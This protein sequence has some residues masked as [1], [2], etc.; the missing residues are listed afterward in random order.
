MGRPKARERELLL[1]IMF[2]QHYL[3]RNL[4]E[5]SEKALL[6]SRCCFVWRR[7]NDH[8]MY[9]MTI[10]VYSKILFLSC[11]KFYTYI[12]SLLFCLM[13]SLVVTSEASSS[14]HDKLF[15]N[16]CHFPCISFDLICEMVALW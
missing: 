14:S 4:W 15:N 7:Y 9:I 10:I 11:V 6:K 12:L 16:H 2:K 1:V 8:M 13:I 5:D 3:D